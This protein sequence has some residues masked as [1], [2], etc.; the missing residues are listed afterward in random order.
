MSTYIACDIFQTRVFRRKYSLVKTSKN[1]PCQNILTIQY[2]SQILFSIIL[3]VGWKVTIYN[4]MFANT[5]LYLESTTSI[6][7][8]LVWSAVYGD[9]F[10]YCV[11]YK[12]S[13]YF[14]TWGEGGQEFGGSPG[15]SPSTCI[16][17]VLN[18]WL[19]E[20][21]SHRWQSLVLWSILYIIMMMQ[22]D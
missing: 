10:A 6:H 1:F 3:K 17:S 8:T 11:V 22:S 4:E 16:M 21:R 18:F 14:W 19:G 13:V 12:S 5:C 7:A 20:P 15:E 9:V 2:I